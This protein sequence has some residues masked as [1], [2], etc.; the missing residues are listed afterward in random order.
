MWALDA[1]VEAVQGTIHRVEKQRFSAISTDLEDNKAGEALHPSQGSQ[2][3]RPP[4]HCEA[5]DRSTAGSLCDKC[6]TEI[7]YLHGPRRSIVLVDDT[8]QA[9]LDLA[10]YKENIRPPHSSP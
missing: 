9:L 4:V 2:F 7:A 3:R 5:F 6:R 10:R 1:I 8:N